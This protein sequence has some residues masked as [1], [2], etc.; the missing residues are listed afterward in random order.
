MDPTEIDTKRID[1]LVKEYNKEL[2]IKGSTRIQSLKEE[3]DQL[4]LINP[5]NGEYFVQKYSRLFSKPLPVPAAAAPKERYLSLLGPSFRNVPTKVPPK[6]G[7]SRR[8]RNKKGKKKTNK[9]RR[10]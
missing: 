1:D 9:R 10:N 8:R 4:K 7:K 6:G 3:I 5:A 2:K